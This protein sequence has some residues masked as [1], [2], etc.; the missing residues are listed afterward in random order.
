M[1]S[2]W[3]PPRY[4]MNSDST[5]PENEEQNFYYFIRNITA[6]MKSQ[7]NTEVER[8]SPIN[9]PENIFAEWEHTKMVS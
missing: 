1:A 4:M 3:S 5:L 2:I 9:E 8:V 6:L 7:F